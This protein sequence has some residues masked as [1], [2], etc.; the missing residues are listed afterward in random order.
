GTCRGEDPGQRRPLRDLWIGN[1]SRHEPRGGDA[2][3]AGKAPAREDAARKDGHGCACWKG[4]GPLTQQ[5]KQPR[6]TALA[7]FGRNSALRKEV[8]A[9]WSKGGFSARPLVTLA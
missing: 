7:V 4:Q 6:E 3:S 1:G 9:G 8:W 2:R 5:C